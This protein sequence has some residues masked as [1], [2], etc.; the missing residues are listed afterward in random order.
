MG[1]NFQKFKGDLG[2]KVTHKSRDNL[3]GNFVHLRNWVGSPGLGIGYID[4]FHLE[5]IMEPPLKR[6]ESE[7]VSM[8]KL[9]A[10]PPVVN[11][12]CITFL[13]LYIYT[14]HSVE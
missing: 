8:V 11:G 9:H 13:R 7:N 14:W 10:L 5:A 1:E 6:M 3:G 4:R 12:K 2:G